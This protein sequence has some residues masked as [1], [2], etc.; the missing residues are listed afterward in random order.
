MHVL[1]DDA[2]PRRTPRVRSCRSG[3]RMIPTASADHEQIAR[4]RV[5]APDA[6]DRRRLFVLVALRVQGPIAIARP[7]GGEDDRIQRSPPRATIAPSPGGCRRWN[8]SM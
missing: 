5:Q 4:G 2:A 1:R 3:A 7:I 8:R 6:G